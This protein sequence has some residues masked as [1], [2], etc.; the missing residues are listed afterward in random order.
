MSEDEGTGADEPEES[1]G[2]RREVPVLTP[3]DPADAA[4]RSEFA[5]VTSLRT[6]AAAEVRVAGMIDRPSHLE[7][8]PASLTTPAGEHEST[9]GLGAL[10]Q[11]L[12]NEVASQRR[13]LMA[14]IDDRFAKLDAALRDA[15]AELRGGRSLEE[16]DPDE[17]A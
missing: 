4:E 15:L 14:A 3:P 13:D 8:S 17:P 6:G 10:E 5:P 11:R 7:S 12:L 2:D 1:L 9:D 16:P